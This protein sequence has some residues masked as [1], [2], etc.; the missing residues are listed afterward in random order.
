MVAPINNPTNSVLGFPFPTSSPTFV[1]Y[2]HEMPPSPYTKFQCEY[3]VWFHG[4]V[5]LFIINI[6]LF[7]TLTNFPEHILGARHC[8][9]L[10]SRETVFGGF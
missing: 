1:I 10:G 3:S 5:C 4:S 6:V 7:I 8:S 9:I 2:G